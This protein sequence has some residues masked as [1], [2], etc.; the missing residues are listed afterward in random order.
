M[1]QYTIVIT[2]CDRF[3]LLDR[4]LASL[5]A[6]VDA[7]PAAVIVMEDSGNVGVEAVCARHFGGRVTAVVNPVRR[8]QIRSIDHA[9]GL[10]TTPY[11][12]HCEDD[13]E[14]F[15]TGFITESQKLL[16]A[17][18]NISMVSLRARGEINPINRNAPKKILG[19]L[20]Y[21]IA[22]PAAHVEYNSYSF[23]PGLRRLADYTRH[24]PFEA[25]KTGLGGIPN[26][27]DVSY[28]FKRRGFAM[29]YLEAPAVRH[30]GW[31][32]HIDDPHHPIRPRTFGGR[33]KRSVHKRIKRFAR[34]RAA[35][36]AERLS[37]G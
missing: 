3:D 2:S 11:I 16:D 8:G 26:E 14:F 12:F 5:D 23:N 18:P 21:F 35:E 6:H 22:D 1:I 4:T 33:L 20:E 30:I 7:A 10:V 32:R 31:E 37:A 25:A 29:A 9:Y 15:R 28:H 19:D 17:L 24:G 13:W 34:R 27:A 36:A